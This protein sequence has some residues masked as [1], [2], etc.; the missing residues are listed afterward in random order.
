MIKLGATEHSSLV[1]FHFFFSGNCRSCPCRFWSKYAASSK[2]IRRCPRN[3]VQLNTCFT[4]RFCAKQSCICIWRGCAYNK[5]ISTCRKHQKGT[6]RS[7]A[8]PGTGTT[9]HLCC[10]ST[11]ESRGKWW[12]W[13]RVYVCL[14]S[15][16]ISS[17][18]VDLYHWHCSKNFQGLMG[19]IYFLLRLSL[20]LR[21][22]CQFTTGSLSL[23]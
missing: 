16:W 4:V 21:C 22:V 23:V 19:T 5:G 18:Y 12:K 13:C 15:G 11:E 8:G 17:F 10:G 14:I 6:S 2:S 1:L 9:Y 3:M 20:G 7:S